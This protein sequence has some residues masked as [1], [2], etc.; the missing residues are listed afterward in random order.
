MKFGYL[1]RLDIHTRTHENKLL[2]VMI[3]SANKL[4][5]INTA[6]YKSPSDIS[7]YFK[8]YCVLHLVVVMG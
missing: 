8:L 5:K 3:N 4:I 6:P 2:S 1:Q 7:Q